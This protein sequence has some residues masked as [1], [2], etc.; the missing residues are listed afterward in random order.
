MAMMSTHHSTDIAAILETSG[1]EI[2]RV[3]D[4][5][6]TGKCPVHI[7]TVGRE[8]RSPSWS[9]N[10]STGLWICFSCGARGTLSS[11]LYEL[12]GDR[13][14]SAQQF[15]INSGLDRLTNP[16]SR[17]H[18]EPVVDRD[19]FF[20]FERVS[21]RRCRLKNLDPDIVYRFGVRWNPSNKSWAI[22]IISSMGQLQGWQEKKPGWVRNFP[23]G[24]KKGHT[25]FGIERFTGRTAVLVESPL[26]IVRFAS[27]YKRP[28]ALAS[29]G[30]HVTLEQMDLLLHVADSVVVAMDNDEAGVESGKKIYKIMS[31][32]RKGIKWWN[33]SGTDAKDIG[34]MTDEE[35]EHGFKTATVVPPWIENV[36]R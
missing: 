6:I 16:V 1:V 3:G 32:P 26:D 20:R 34:D 36:Q 8:D 9:I 13:A 5:E 21:D 31:T 4:R 18:T 25:L 7:R 11:L 17:E 23:V 15:L 29:F 10:A 24:V 22:P 14:S 27:V 12:I 28:C 33:Y 19:A 2:S 35:I 30:A